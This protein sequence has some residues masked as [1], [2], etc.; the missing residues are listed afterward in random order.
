VPKAART[1]V[2]FLNWRD[3][4]HPEGGG[5][6]RYVHR[7]AEG[8][9]ASGLRVTLL[10]AAHGRAPREEHRGGVRVLRR[11]GRLTV[12]PRGLLHVLL[13]RPR[14]VVDVQNGV[15]FGSPLVTRRPV[16]VLVHHVHRE[17]WPILFGRVVGALGWWLESRVAPR[18][19]RRCR[20]VTVSPSTA[21]ELVQVGV[22]AARVCIVPNGTEPTPPVRTR[23]DPH[24]RL[25]VLG[26]RVPH[27]RVEHAIEAVARLHRS[28]PGLRLD[29]VGDGWWAPELRAHAERLGVA[30]RVAFHGHVDEQ[31]KHELLA[32]AWVHVCPSVKEGWGIAVTE[33]AG[34]GVP[35]VAYGSAGGLR[36]SVRDGEGGLLVDDLD[37]LVGAVDRL[38]GDPAARAVLGAGAARYA[39][40]YSWPASVT[41]FGAA[42]DA[43]GL[44]LARPA[45]MRSALAVVDG[46]RRRR[47]GGRV[48]VQRGRGAEDRGHRDHGPCD[49]RDCDSCERSHSDSRLPGARRPQ[50][51]TRAA[52]VDNA[53]RSRPPAAAA[54]A[55]PSTAASA[56]RCAPSTASTVRGPGAGSGTTD[57]TR[58]RVTQ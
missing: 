37:G 13:S 36:D 21:A 28:H 15:P 25:V 31:T 26:R 11:G 40:G 47:L 34:H 27:K 38:L 52:A 20:Y 53:E 57:G 42:L 12:Y 9:A 55:E 7:V 58:R 51:V 43:A 3:A 8:L 18:I 24:P 1:D 16:V 23:T 45:S 5:S 49:Q 56:S 4:T 48:L 50:T 14:A 6:E 19:Y 46:G 33:A 2:L 10:C 32:A 41:A 39:A 17:Q 22:A 29:V 30:D 54:S 44:D 35:T